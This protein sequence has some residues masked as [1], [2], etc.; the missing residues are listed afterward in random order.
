MDTPDGDNVKEVSKL[1]KGDFVS[2][3]ADQYVEVLDVRQESTVVFLDYS[4]PLTG[5]REQSQY[6][7]QDL[8][9][10]KKR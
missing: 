1:R 6:D 10:I 4:N 9:V 8:V 3:W 2:W 5:L 7:P